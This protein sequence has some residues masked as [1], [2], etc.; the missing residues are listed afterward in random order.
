MI[1]ST[2]SVPSSTTGTAMAGISVARRFCRKMNITSVTSTMASA[3]VLTTSSMDAR[4]N[5]VLSEL[6]TPLMPSG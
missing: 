3:R 1:D 2:P 5:G 6:T 4:T